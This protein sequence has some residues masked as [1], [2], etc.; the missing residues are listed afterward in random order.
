M[1]K[2]WTNIKDNFMKYMK[3]KESANKSGA[4]ATKIKEYH[5]YKQLMFLKKNAPNLT[6]SSIL[7]DESEDPKRSET[8]Q[9]HVTNQ[10]QLHEKE[11]T[12][13]M[14]LKIKL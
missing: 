8:T 2:K 12:V 4:G 9:G 7:E 11:S 13:K 10:L 1:V 5:L 14:I 6:D 3:K